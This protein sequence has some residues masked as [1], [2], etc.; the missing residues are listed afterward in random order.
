MYLSQPMRYYILLFII[1]STFTLFGQNDTADSLKVIW[2]SGADIS[3][4]A[5]VS[6]LLEIAEQTKRQNFD[7]AF[8]YANLA[9]EK[10]ATSEWYQKK[11]DGY[12]ILAQS[13]AMLGNNEEGLQY[14]ERMLEN[15]TLLNDKSQ[16][17]DAYMGIKMFYQGAGRIDDA[18]AIL[19]DAVSISEEVN[20]DMQGE[21]FHAF[22]S[23]HSKLNNH[24]LA[25]NYWNKALDI[26]RDF[27]DPAK[28]CRNVYNLGAA[29]LT[30]EQPDIGLPYLQESFEL[31]EEHGYTSIQVASGTMLGQYYS[32]KE[33][34]ER[35]EQY[36]LPA[37][38]LAKQFNLTQYVSVT[39]MILGQ[40][41]VK[42]GNTNKGIEY[43]EESKTIALELEDLTTQETATK[44]LSEAYSIYGDY[45][46][47]LENSL[48]A[49]DIRDSL[50]QQQSQEEL[51]ELEQVYQVKEKEA[52]LVL[53]DSQLARQRLMNVGIGV[54][55]VLLLLLFLSAW[56]N[57]R[58]RKR[59]NAEL[60]QL[61]Q[62]KSQ[63]FTN[64]S[65]ELRTPISLILGP[66]ENALE[67]NK[68][69]HISNQLEIA[70]QSGQKLLQLVDEIMDLSKLESGKLDL[71]VKEINIHS[72]ILRIFES[73]ESLADSLKIHFK[74]E[75]EV[76]E[77]IF[78]KI[79]IGK[80]E[81]V[82]NNLISN[83]LKFTPRDGTVRLSVVQP[84]DDIFQLSVTDSGEGIPPDDLNKVFDRYFQS[85]QNNTSRGGTGIGLALSKELISLMGGEIKVDSELGVGSTFTIRLPLQ[86]EK[87]RVHSSTKSSEAVQ[88]EV[89]QEYNPLVLFEE[90]PNLLVIEDNESMREY[91]KSILSPAYRCSFAKDGLEGLDLLKTSSFDAVTCDVMMPNMDGFQ[92][93]E[94]LRKNELHHKIPVVMLTARSL[95]EDKLKGFSLGVDDYIT[96]PFNKR[97]LFAR[98]NTLLS[99][100][101]IRES[102]HEEF[103]N[104]DKD[105][106]EDEMLKKAEQLVINHLTDEQYN[107][108]LLSND[109]NYSPRQL[110]RIMKK[111]TGMTPLQ[112][113][114]EIRLRKAYQILTSRQFATVSEVRY[115][116]GIP[117]AS[118]F[119]KEF[120]KRFGVK[121]NELI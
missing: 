57:L 53:Q 66:I 58:Q 15:A 68:S 120:E 89:H 23:L 13:S 29:Y 37:Y 93:M 109:M 106:V 11:I 116:V 92:F 12:K 111:L 88:E 65:H 80:F 18:I 117:H 34:F 100:K 70:Q 91:L 40:Y 69:K 54:V 61:D 64:I 26:T 108:S 43:L 95:E 38:N 84:S 86:I 36:A 50:Y 51:L 104:G 35:S 97:E 44:F 55:A 45:Q 32:G 81:K 98:I 105:T 75:Y 19:E 62:T 22:A 49:H 90:Q 118:Y 103:D 3:K 79:D 28:Y 17:V 33:L 115:E 101:K 94:H 52:Q 78:V 1:C 71:N 85:S 27:E 48:L 46:K 7:T 83:S 110:G 14:C 112:F 119:A 30:N 59:V 41:Y 5:E 47:A 87:Q 10:A 114:R 39:A 21:I 113:I 16:M 102:I 4:E 20:A 9:M 8:R 25:I 121:P 72:L 56:R 107:V 73:F 99:N 31:G 74:F 24:E 67:L 2:T 96:K 6:L 42:S 77:S 76:E 63:F 60:R 82:L